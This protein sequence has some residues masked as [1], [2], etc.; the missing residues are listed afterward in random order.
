MQSSLQAIAYLNRQYLPQAQIIYL[1]L[2]LNSQR[3]TGLVT[4][5]ILMRLYH[6]DMPHDSNRALAEV[7][8]SDQ[9]RFKPTYSLGLRATGLPPRPS[10]FSSFWLSWRRSWHLHKGEILS[11]VQQGFHPYRHQGVLETDTFYTLMSGW[12]AR[13]ST[14]WIIRISVGR[15]TIL[16]T[17]VWRKQRI[18]R[19]WCR[20][21]NEKADCIG[22]FKRLIRKVD[23]KSWFERLIQK[24]DPKV[25]RLIR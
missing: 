15:S 5:I 2:S 6:L 7:S 19:Q 17:Y 8:A 23:L 12:S 9:V 18:T 24:I 3:P 25:R 14:I 11:Y 22:W 20:R 16:R 1:D 13:R 4:C 10:S 21:F